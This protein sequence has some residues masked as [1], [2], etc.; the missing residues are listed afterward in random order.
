[1]SFL[2]QENSLSCRCPCSGRSRQQMETS[3]GFHPGGE[4]CGGGWQG[5]VR[6]YMFVLLGRFM[7]P[8]HCTPTILYQKKK[9]LLIKQNTNQKTFGFYFFQESKFITKLNFSSKAVSMS[10]CNC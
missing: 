4:C 1:M 3:Q 5:W 2:R 7:A 8:C 10:Q 9:K 6:L